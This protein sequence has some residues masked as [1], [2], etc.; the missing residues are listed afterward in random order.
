MT[1]SEI[2][3]TLARDRRAAERACAVGD[4]ETLRRVGL[5][6]EALRR[7]FAR[8]ARGRGYRVVIERTVTP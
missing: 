6:R 4:A 3:A 8:L 7:A 2:A 1:A 5:R